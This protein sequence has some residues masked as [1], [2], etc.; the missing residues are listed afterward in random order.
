MKDQR[1]QT[2][3][4][5]DAESRWRLDN[6]Y[7]RYL[8]LSSLKGNTNIAFLLCPYRA[9]CSKINQNRVFS[10]L[11]YCPNSFTGLYVVLF[12]ATWC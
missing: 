10:Y 4:D 2:A 9:I 1:E 3:Q 7:E 5:I 6:N 8:D 11:L 12:I